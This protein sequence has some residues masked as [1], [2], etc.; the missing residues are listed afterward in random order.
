MLNF[1]QWL[2]ESDPGFT[3]LTPAT[4]PMPQQIP[5]NLP[6]IQ[7]KKAQFYVKKIP[8][9]GDIKLPRFDSHEE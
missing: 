3:Q 5:I 6:T 1:K 9:L 7:K 8:A 2:L 4:G